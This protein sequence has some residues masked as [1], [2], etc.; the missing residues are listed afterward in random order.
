[1]SLP[2]LLVEDRTNESLNKSLS[3][4]GNDYAIQSKHCMHA[5]MHVQGTCHTRQGGIQTNY[6]QFAE[7][8]VV[9]FVTHSLA[10]E[11]PFRSP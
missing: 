3:S 9:V 5:G 1:M 4:C 6:M 2:K 10:V 11:C 7:R 8:S